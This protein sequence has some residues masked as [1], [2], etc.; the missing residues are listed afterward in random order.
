MIADPRAGAIVQSVLSLSHV[1]GLEVVAEGVS[2]AEM[3]GALIE[4]G[5]ERG[6]GN[7]LAEA[8]PAEKVEAALRAQVAR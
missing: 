4:L 6:Q 7:F 3:V 5:C 2:T 8:M 1:L